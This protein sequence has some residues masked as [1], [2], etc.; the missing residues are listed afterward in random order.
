MATGFQLASPSAADDLASTGALGGALDGEL[1]KLWEIKDV[2][3][4]G[5]VAGIFN[6]NEIQWSGVTGYA[7]IERRKLM[8]TDTVL[9]IGSISKTVT[10]TALMQLFDRGDV[11]L[12]S[13]VSDY[14]PFSLRNPMFPQSRITLRQLLTHTSSLTDS[15]RYYES[16]SCGDPGLS[17]RDWIRSYATF[18]ESGVQVKSSFLDVR[19]GDRYRYSNVG[20]GVLGLVVEQVSG[21]GFSKYCR[22]NLFEPLKMDQTGWHLSEIDIDTHATMYAYVSPTGD[23]KDGKRILSASGPRKV[24]VDKDSFLPHCLY[25]FPNYPD[26]LVRTSFKNLVRFAQMFLNGG[27]LDGRRILEPSTVQ[28]M[29]STQTDKKEGQ[30]FAWSSDVA[31]NGTVVWQHH[32]GDPGVLTCLRFSPQNQ[33]GMIVLQNCDRNVTFARA[34]EL[35]DEFLSA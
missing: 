12:D 24:A 1:A 4:P 23:H 15:E 22:A 27:Q 26:G 14:L 3:C 2:P 25:S 20:F 32:G 16:Y 13:D 6:A 34:V 28:L 33:L 19:P 17:L 10:A 5:V 21:L 8:S 30:G 18:G 11:A 29:L 9:N 35:L 7:D 31:K